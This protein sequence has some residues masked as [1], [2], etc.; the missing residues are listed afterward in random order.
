[1]NRLTVTI[2]LLIHMLSHPRT[3][4]VS[5]NRRKMMRKG[6]SRDRPESINRGYILNNFGGREMA[7]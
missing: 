4:G 7:R 6:E 1:M 2:N 3:R 5:F